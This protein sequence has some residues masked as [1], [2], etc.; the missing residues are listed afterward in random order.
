MRD[1]EK[2]PDPD[3]DPAG[4]RGLPPTKA[5]ELRLSDLGR[6]IRESI[7]AHAEEI[8]LEAILTPEEAEPVKLELWRGRGVHALLDPEL[9]AQLRMTKRQREELADALKARLPIYHKLIRSSVPVYRRG[10]PRAEHDPARQ[11]S[12]DER[13]QKVAA[14][15]QPIWEILTDSQLRALATLLKQPVAGYDPAKPRAKPRL[16]GRDG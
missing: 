7:V 3:S 2:P 11:Q 10:A 4:I 14:L 12:R 13:A 5:M 6:M 1:I 16:R 9:A 15:D 8:A